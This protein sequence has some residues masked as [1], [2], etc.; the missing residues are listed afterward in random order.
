MLE[1]E[2]AWVNLGRLFFMLEVNP[3]RKYGNKSNIHRYGFLLLLIEA[4]LE[5]V[6][7]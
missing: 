6:V 7:V 3:G 1:I 4:S 5:S 2:A